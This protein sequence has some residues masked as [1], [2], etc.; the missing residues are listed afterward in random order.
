[1][2]DENQALGTNILSLLEVTQREA[3]Y[4]VKTETACA[5]SLH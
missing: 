2:R 4:H 5:L 1:M 3:G